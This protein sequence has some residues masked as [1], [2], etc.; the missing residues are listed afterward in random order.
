[1]YI[2]VFM[3]EI[4]EKGNITGYFTDTRKQN[5]IFHLFLLLGFVEF[6]E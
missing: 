1:M 3:F 5:F 6:Y 2:N 4:I